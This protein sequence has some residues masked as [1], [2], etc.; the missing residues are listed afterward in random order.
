VPL[1][2]PTNTET[3]LTPG[4]SPGQ[5]LALSPFDKAQ[6]GAGMGEGTFRSKEHPEWLSLFLTLAPALR[7]REG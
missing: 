5:A 1:R 3:A 4:S 7:E 2:S 6:G